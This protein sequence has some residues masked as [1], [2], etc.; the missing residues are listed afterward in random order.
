MQ[1]SSNEADREVDW[2]ISNP[3][4]AQPRRVGY[5]RFFRARTQDSVSVSVEVNCGLGNKNRVYEKRRIGKRREIELN[6]P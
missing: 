3:R 4:A 5:T 2:K 6:S 1:A